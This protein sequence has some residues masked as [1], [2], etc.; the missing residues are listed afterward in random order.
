MTQTKPILVIEDDQALRE[1]IC[2]V[3]RD[4]GYATVNADTGETA[5]ALMRSGSQPSLV[6]LDLMM[7]TMN[8]WQFRQEQLSDPTIADIP[9]VVMTASRNLEGRPI[10]AQRILH[11]PVSISAIVAAIDDLLPSAS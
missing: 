8:G 9:V 10:D 6:L 5:L 4:E 1:A 2:D 3:L 11:K 7:P